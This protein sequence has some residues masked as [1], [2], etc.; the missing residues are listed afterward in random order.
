M[1]AGFP[2]HVRLTFRTLLACFAQAR[3]YFL[4]RAG[5]FVVVVVVVVVDLVLRV[6]VKGV[7]PILI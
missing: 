2:D 7:V 5:H 4:I 1:D 3:A 6:V